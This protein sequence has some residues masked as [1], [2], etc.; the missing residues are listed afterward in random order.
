MTKNRF[1]RQS[2][3]GEKGQRQIERCVVGV[4]GLGGGG[5]HIV[6]QLAHLG[7]RNYVLFDPDCIKDV[8]L[9]RTVGATTLDEE[10]G[11]P[12]AYIALRI[13]RSLTPSANVLVVTKKWQ[14]RLDALMDCDLVF[15]CLDGFAERRDI[16]AFLRGRLIPYID[17]GM[18]VDHRDLT[19]PPQIVGQ[20]ILSMPGKPCMHCI[21]FLTEEKLAREAENYGDAGP[22]PQVVWPNGVL[23]STAVGVGVDLLTNWTRRAPEVVFMSYR[24]NSFELVP[25]N[26]LLIVKPGQMCSHFPIDATG[27]R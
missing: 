27:I 24:G 12:K 6:Q 9:N 5:S 1:A 20:V 11:A 19:N 23:A 4:V 3:L 7:F 13:I 17:I 18:D 15:G 21:G 10:T 22:M 26:R 25:D 16:E 8:N 2:F 14:E